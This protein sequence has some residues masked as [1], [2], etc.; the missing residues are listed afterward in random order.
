MPRELTVRKL[1]SAHD[2]AARIRLGTARTQPA[3]IRGDT[4][5]PGIPRTPCIPAFLVRV[6]WGPIKKGPD[7]PVLVSIPAAATPRTTSPG[8]IL[9]TQIGRASCRERV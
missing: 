8:D 6:L 1:G 2:G 9:I 5:H 4:R 7:P 3:G